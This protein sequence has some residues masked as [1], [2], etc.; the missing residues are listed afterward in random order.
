MK[1]FKDLAVEL[2]FQNF[3]STWVGILR[4]STEEIESAFLSLWNLRAVTGEL[5]WYDH[6]KQVAIFWTDKQSMRR[7]FFNRNWLQ[8]V[9]RSRQFKYACLIHA[10]TAL[11]TLQE[12][13]EMFVK[14]DMGGE[15]DFYEVGKI[16]AERPDTD[17]KSAVL[18]HAFANKSA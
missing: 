4:G 1:L 12:C 13:C 6:A 14:F 11:A 17:F 15:P 18:K 2:S 5:E 3:G 9:D 7:Y 10:H 16:K 8:S